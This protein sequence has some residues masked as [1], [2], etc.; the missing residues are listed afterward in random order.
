MPKSL[1]H[2]TQLIFSPLPAHSDYMWMSLPGYMH[3][4]EAGL[5]LLEAYRL[6]ILSV[7]T[8]QNVHIIHTIS[9]MIPHCNRYINTLPEEV[10]SGKFSMSLFLH[11]AYS[12]YIWSLPGKVSSSLWLV[13]VWQSSYCSKEKQDKIGPRGGSGEN[14][15]RSNEP[16]CACT[17]INIRYT[18][19]TL[20]VWKNI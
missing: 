20:Y 2:K 16:V 5:D 8:V 7:P 4:K 3:S 10:S 1:R 11:C 12:L 19:Y 15:Y 13:F 9:P 18:V 17:K 6:S 14:P